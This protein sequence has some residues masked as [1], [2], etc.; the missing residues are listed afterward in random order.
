[1]YRTWDD[2]AVAGNYKGSAEFC[3]V[4]EHTTTTNSTSTTKLAKSESTSAL[5]SSLSSFMSPTPG[6]KNNNK[7]PVR[8]SQSN[9]KDANNKSTALT[10]T[11]S[12]TT[13]TTTI[14]AFLLGKSVTKANVDMR[15]YIQWVVVVPAFCR[16]G[17]ALSLISQFVQ[18]GQ[19]Q[20]ISLLLGNTPA[21]NEPAIEMFQKAGLSHKA[22]HVYLT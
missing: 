7:K 1:M 17:I 12:T 4:A 21:D 20:N 18:V 22:D 19:Q 6:H 2:Y 10:T 11:T 5:Q 9:V 13:T 8:K 15:G 16:F 3:F 14:V